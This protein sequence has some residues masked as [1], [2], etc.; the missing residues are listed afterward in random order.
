MAGLFDTFTIAKRG[1]SVQQ[2]NINTTSHNISNA[3]TTG[4][5]RQRAVVETTKPFGGLSRFD[6]C[7]AGQVGT[8]AEVT[9]I[10]RIR[11]VFKDYQVREQKSKYGKLDQENQFLT[12]V[13]DILNETSDTGIQGA[14]SNFYNGFQTLSLDPTKSSNRTV[15][16]QD[17][18]TLANALN[19]RYTSLETKKSDAQ[20]LLQTDVVDINSTL[21]QINELNKQITSVS[22]IGMSPN[23]LMD[24][25]D[26]LLDDLS[27]KFGITVN[28]EKNESVDVS[29]SELSS[30]GKII[31]G[32]DLTGAKD[33]RFSCIESATFDSTTNDLTVTYSVLG[34]KTNLK[35]IKIA[36]A[37]EALTKE[38]LEKRILIADKDGTPIDPTSGT[39][40]ASSTT[41]ADFDKAL[42]KVEKGEIGGI[43]SVQTQIQ[44]A[45]DDLD[46]FAAGLAYSVNAIATGSTDFATA[47][48]NLANN[49]PLF[50]TK[51][52]AT[53]DG[54]SAKT[55][56]INDTITSDPNK[57]N[58]GKDKT[59]G[60]KDGT[61]ALA[62]ADMISKKMDLTK[63]DV[64]STSTRKEFFTN[65]ATTGSG[66]NF[67]AGKLNLDSST[68][69]GK[70]GDFYKSLVSN[71]A[72][73]TKGVKSEFATAS[74]DLDSFQNDRLSE[75]GVSLDEETANLI[76]Y[77]HAYQASAKVISTVDELLDVVINGLKK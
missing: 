63:I 65:T 77:Q 59:S 46:K 28:R 54:I 9:T 29:A 12:E 35:T 62:I 42:F 14:L 61:R 58:C 20:S 68:T 34:D 41:P 7:G 69:G 66:L 31:D 48:S 43:Q 72:T 30:M 16:I 23:D 2:A 27:T 40:I 67:D 10:Q 13:G 25:R 45:M 11:D 55:I 21:N 76:Q 38:V 22:A 74:D 8:G 39:A 26:N 18:S 52:A 24:K 15:A 51:G 47:N 71:L 3:S 53:D 32:T 56:T 6:T 70:L 37:T 57:L 73:V 5:S 19:N 49:D 50:V 75:S 44:K 4:Y 36:G 17:A 1:L 64:T 33:K 60:D